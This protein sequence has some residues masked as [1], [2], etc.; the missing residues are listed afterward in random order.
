[1]DSRQVQ[2][3]L[4]KLSLRYGFCNTSK[5]RADEYE[6]WK[7]FY[8]SYL[9]VF[10]VTGTAGAFPVLGLRLPGERD[11]KIEVG[12]VLCEVVNSNKFR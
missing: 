4:K 9:N 10:Q 1:M 12:T 6:D 3:F 8:Y 2:D 11:I 5:L 7:G